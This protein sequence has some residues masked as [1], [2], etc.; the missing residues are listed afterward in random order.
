M[1]YRM[2]QDWIALGDDFTITDEN[3]DVVAR[4]DGKVFSIGDKLSFLDAQGREMGVISERIISLR[5]TYEILR[6]G[7]VVGVVSKDL[8][9]LFRC[10]FTVD[11]PG[12]D[13]L[14]ARG[15][16]L[17]HDYEFTRHGKTVATVSKGWL[18]FRDSYSI[19][20]AH[21]EDAFL[22]VASAV[23][24]DLCCHNGRDK[25]SHD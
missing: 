5:S 20:V 15:N 24:I 8:F 11:V 9:S 25:K 22:I 21:G 12:P 18:N 2:K 16:L 17:D 23:V 4:V 10:S 19:D 13:D 7:H 6:N 14:E 3:G 1:K